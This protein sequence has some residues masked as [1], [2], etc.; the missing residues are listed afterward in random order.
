VKAASIHRR[1]PTLT[2]W[3]ARLTPK[4]GFAALASVLIVLPWLI[5]DYQRVFVAEIFIW[6]LF[7]MSFAMVFGYGGML[8]FAQAVFFGAGCYGFNLGTFYFGFN[9]WGAVASAFLAAVLFALPIGFIATRVRHHHF[10]IVTVIVSVLVITVL[11][12]GHWKWLAG[13]YVTRSLTFV[14]EVP[15]GIVSFSFFDET[16]VYYFTV[17]MVGAAFTACWFLVHSPFGRA[18]LAIRDNETRAQMIGYNVNRLRWIMFVVAAGVAGYA[19]ALY[20]LLARY[21]NL[22]FFHWTYSGKAIVMAIIGGVGSLLG[23]FVGTAFY[24]LSNEYLSQIFEQFAVLVGFIL[25]IVIRYAP[26][27]LWGLLVGWVRG[28]RSA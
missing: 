24:L 20:A 3:L 17:T 13:P 4:Q 22:E 8:S 7:A 15:L 21:T 6:G 11:D 5:P 10:L 2:A 27:G 12:S 1:E 23:P 19:G 25:L 9:T 14:P 26:E 28:Q 16:V 18:L